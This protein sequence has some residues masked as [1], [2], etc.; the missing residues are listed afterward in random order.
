MQRLGLCDALN[1]GEL[2]KSLLRSLQPQSSPSGV[3]VSL[4]FF[5]VTAIAYGEG[6]FRDVLVEQTGAR[7]SLHGQIG[8]PIECLI[9]AYLLANLLLHLL[10]YFHHYY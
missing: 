9:E 2:F 5:F 3:N 6:V 4:I 1:V 10:N 8:R 7:S